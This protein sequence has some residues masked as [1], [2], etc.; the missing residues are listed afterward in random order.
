MGRFARSL[1]LLK[2]S[3]SVL[4]ADKELVLL[5]VFS[6][7]ASLV[8]MVGFA[9]PLLVLSGMLDGGGSA[10]PGPLTYV[11]TFLMYLVL[12]YI[13]I[14]FNT[15]LL[16]AADQRLHGGDP[17][18][19][20]ALSAAAS[21]AG[22]ILPWAIVAATVNVVLR[23]IADRAGPVGAIVAGIVGMAWNVVTF[24]VL[25]ILVFENV[26]VGEGIKRSTQL[27][28]RTWGENLVGNGGIGLIG[29]LAILPA[30][31]L[32]VAVASTGS[33]TAIITVVVIAAV[34]ILL[35]SVVMTALSGIYQL[36]LYRFA[37]QG[38]VPAQFAGVDLRASYKI[39]GRRR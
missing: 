35:V 32:V 26:G 37:A 22:R 21:R 14:F 15:A 33:A 20:S 4:R 38:I 13:T 7:I 9:V 34:W 12:S 6:G 19:G 23:A 11:G 10:E 28:K 31:L 16:C 8:V 3:A 25:P 36:V 24:L 27:F 1:Q 39:Q 5:P 2:A 17:T 18:L 30:V 29:F